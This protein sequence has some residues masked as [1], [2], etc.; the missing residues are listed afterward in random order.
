MKKIIIPGGTGFIG[1]ALIKDYLPKGYS[2]TV[3]GRDKNKIQTLFADTVTAVDWDEFSKKPE[4]YLE[5][6]D[7]I[8]NLTGANISDGRWSDARKKI[9]IDSRIKPTE[10]LA[11]ACATLGDKSPLFYSASGI[12]RYGL[13][14]NLDVGL[15]TALDEYSEI[16][17]TPDFMYQLATQRENATQVAINAKVPVI[18]LRFGVVLD[19]NGGALPQIALPFKLCVGGPVGSGQQPFSWIAL[20]DLCAAIDFLIAHPEITGPVNLVAPKCI[21][22]KEFA[23]SLGNALRRPSIMPSPEWAMRLI[24]GQMADE[25]LLQGQHVVPTRLLE[26]GFKF[27][28]PDIQGTLNTIYKRN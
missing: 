7:V 4:S 21:T 6:N 25:L 12:G 26:S 20:T 14:A 2:I 24:F 3:L 22:Q 9:L 16:K 13:Q 11:K 5:K 28:T 15:P 1:Q 10:I 18:H 8:I 27:T 19:K 23:H 17:P